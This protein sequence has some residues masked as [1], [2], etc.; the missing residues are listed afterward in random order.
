MK[1]TGSIAFQPS[2]NRY[3]AGQS[4]SKKQKR[5]QKKETSSGERYFCLPDNDELTIT[6]L[7]FIMQYRFFKG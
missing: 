5:Q 1:M 3:A 6:E 2:V 7:L 4:G